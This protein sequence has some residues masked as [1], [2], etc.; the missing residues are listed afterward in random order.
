MSEA[1]ELWVVNLGTVP[2]ED[3]LELQREMAKER[4]SG[5]I[6]QDVLLLLEHPPVVT[7]GRSAKSRNLIGRICIGICDRWRKR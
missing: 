6:P 1:R 5:A 4:I 7:M 2:Y 3:A